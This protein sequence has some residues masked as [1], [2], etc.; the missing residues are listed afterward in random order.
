MSKEKENE[1]IQNKPK[2]STGTLLLAKQ[3]KEIQKNPVEG[4]ILI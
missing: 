4:F 2:T 1:K 3:L